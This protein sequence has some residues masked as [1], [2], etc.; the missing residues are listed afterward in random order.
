M[1][2]RQLR[3]GVNDKNYK[4]IPAV[5]PVSKWVKLGD[6]FQDYF[7]SVYKYTEKQYQDFQTTHTIKGVDDVT[8]DWL[9]FDFDNSD[10][11]ELAQKDSVE[12]VNRLL[13][14]NIPIEDIRISFTGSKGVHVELRHTSEFTPHQH[15]TIAYNLAKGLQTFDESVYNHAMPFRVMGSVNKKSGLY[16]IPL[17]FQELKTFTI[18]EIKDK[19]KNLDAVD[20]SK[21]N[22]GVVE[23]P[24]SILSLMTS[25][26]EVKTVAPV[27]GEPTYRDFKVDFLNKVK[28]FSNCKWSMTYGYGL[29][30]G[31]RKSKLVS[32]AATCK[33]LNFI[34]GQAYYV[35]K[36]A[37][38]EGSRVYQTP[39]MPKDEIEDIVGQVFSPT[40]KGG[41]YSCKD[42]KT[43]WLTELCKSLEHNQCSHTNE[44][45][46]VEPG[47]VFDMF[48][49]YAENFEK[50]VLYT[51][52][53]SLDER[54]KL[55]VGTSNAIAAPPGVGKTSLSLSI[56]NHNSNND[57]PSIFFSYDMFHSALYMRMLQRHTGKSQDEIYWTFNHDKRQMNEWNEMLKQEYKNVRFCFKS[58]QT[59]QEIE[60]TISDTEDRI[61]KKIKLGIFD[62]NELIQSDYSDATAASAQVAQR[63]RQISNDRSICAVTLLQPSKNYSSPGE[64]MTNFNAA[65]GSSTIVQSLTLMLGCSRPGFNPRLAG[66]IHD[67]DKYFNI[68]CLKNRNGGL[69]SLDFGWKGL[70]GMITELDDNGHA[71]LGSLRASKESEKK[72]GSGW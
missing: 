14:H 19:A 52:I 20:K 65:K 16:K 24:Q 46:T 27:E 41:T 55:M 40:W 32:L 33:S 69:F 66:G 6:P 2:Y 13:K 45:T 67:T 10:H 68:T 50:N 56:L 59:L 7:T 3:Y 9:I 53:H 1:Y 15:K 17:T 71:D 48:K 54:V 38:K 26:I 70:E 44:K 51:G 49:D 8:T 34:E 21:F 36:H 64:E 25:K 47:E 39:E 30:S 57:I 35:I 58:G 42:G 31:E 18:D 60:E 23:I 28:G 63:I 72:D 12:I 62:Y 29:K 61:G 4:L 5:D 43:P 37:M 11:P 22:W